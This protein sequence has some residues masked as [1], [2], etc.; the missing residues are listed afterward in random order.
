MRIDDIRIRLI[1]KDIECY[2]SWMGKAD[3]PYLVCRPLGSLSEKAWA[4]LVPIDDELDDKFIEFIEEK[5]KGLK[6]KGYFK[7]GGKGE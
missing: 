6:E 5:I 3:G 7:E 2:S 4:F 1:A